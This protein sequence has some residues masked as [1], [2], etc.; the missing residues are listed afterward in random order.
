MLGSTSPSVL[1][2]T[3]DDTEQEDRLEALLD[4]RTQML[5]QGVDAVPTDARKTGN[6]L[7]FIV[8]LAV[9]GTEIAIMFGKVRCWA[10][11]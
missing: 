10:L 1:G 3:L 6:R 4:E 11:T 8:L 7:D 2:Q 5:Y 9:K